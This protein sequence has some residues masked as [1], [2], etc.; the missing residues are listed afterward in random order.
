MPTGTKR[1]SDT[2]APAAKRARKSSGAKIVDAILAGPDDYEIPED[3]NEVRELLVSIANYAN[4]LRA[5]ATSGGGAGAAMSEDDVKAAA[6]TLHSA[7][8]KGILRQMTVRAV[9]F[10][11]ITPRRFDSNVLYSGSLPA[12]LVGR[13]SSSTVSAPIQP[14]SGRCSGLMDLRNGR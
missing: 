13:N 1:K 8:Q 7:T 12:R 9:L 3:E 6:E 10:A 2:T 11:S 14:C 5:A 4:K